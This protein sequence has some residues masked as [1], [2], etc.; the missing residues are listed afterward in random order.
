MPYDVKY[1]QIRGSEQGTSV[2]LK[3]GLSIYALSSKFIIRGSTTNTVDLAINAST[4]IM[5]HLETEA[6]ATS[7]GTE[8]R[9]CII[10]SDA[11]YRVP[12]IAGTYSSSLIGR[13]CDIA[14]A[15]GIQGAALASFSYGQLVIVGGDDVDQQYV[16]V[17]LYSGV[18]NVTI[19]A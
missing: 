11:Y 12:I 4:N 10:D 6:I 16:D 1:G 14:T 8:T 9:K 7:L 3:S 13:R 5:G 15:S 17:Y 19:T 18:Q 2:L